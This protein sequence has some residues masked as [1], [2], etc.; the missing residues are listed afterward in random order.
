MAL[1]HLPIKKIFFTTAVTGYIHSSWP[2]FIIT[3]L[4]PLVLALRLFYLY[5][6]SRFLQHCRETVPC[7]VLK[8]IF[9][10]LILE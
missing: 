7:N 4:L 9:K 3:V 8:L 6:N 1:P 5:T 10:F 2:I